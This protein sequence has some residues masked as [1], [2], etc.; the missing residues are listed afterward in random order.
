MPPIGPSL[1]IS[2][3]QLSDVFTSVLQPLELRKKNIYLKKKNPRLRYRYAD[4]RI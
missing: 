1:P 3:A 4:L 2:V